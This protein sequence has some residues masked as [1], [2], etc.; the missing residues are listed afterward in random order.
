VLV[1]SGIGVVL[2]AIFAWWEATTEAPMLDVHF[3]QNP[4]F[5]AASATI[6][7]TYFAMF[8]SMFLMTLY[9]QFILGYSPLKAG[10]MIS[11]I[12]LGLM[13]GSPSAPRFVAR[14]GTKRVVL[15]GLS[16]VTLGFAMYAS[17]T[18]MSTFW[19]AFAVRFLFGMGMGTTTAPLTESIM[20]SLPPERAGVGSAVNDTTRQVGGALGVAVLGSI[21][22]ARYHAA[23]DAAAGVPAQL[24]GTARES[25]GAT[26]GV[27]RASG[28][29][30]GARIRDAGIHAFL[31]SMRLTFACGVVIMTGAMFVAWRFLPSHAIDMEQRLSSETGEALLTGAENAVN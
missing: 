24:R 12:A 13:A 17:N 18:I 28:G 16:I 26:L 15:A 10:L 21:F 19:L 6:T 30:A 4:R 5:S 3:F 29:D 31:T 2:L 7:L 25:I 9:F 22:A 23:M 1:A 8:A 27:A 14:Y 20:G 11:P